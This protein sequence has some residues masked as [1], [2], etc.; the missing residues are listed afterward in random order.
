MTTNKESYG[1]TFDIE[2]IRG[3]I[4]KDKIYMI[5]NNKQGFKAVLKINEEQLK[6]INAFYIWYKYWTTK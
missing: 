2:D 1:R 4:T 5:I 6:R 3:I